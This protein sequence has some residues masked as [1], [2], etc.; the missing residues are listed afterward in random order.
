MNH[1]AEHQHEYDWQFYHA[2]QAAPV[3]AEQHNLT[4]AASRVWYKDF[5]KSPAL[6]ILNSRTDLIN[7]L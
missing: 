2:G 4:G 7:K 1:S 3:A 6:T 5:H